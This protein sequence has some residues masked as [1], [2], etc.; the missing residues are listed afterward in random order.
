MIRRES[1]AETAD[2][3]SEYLRACH[4]P[5]ESIIDNA[6][7]FGEVQKKSTITDLT[8]TTYQA[9]PRTFVVVVHSQITTYLLN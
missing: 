7:G 4:L 5:L 2:A 8:T 3:S 6:S 9:A 1:L